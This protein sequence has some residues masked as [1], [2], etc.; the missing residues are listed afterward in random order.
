M[1]EL[2]SI[3]LCIFFLAVSALATH[4]AVLETM[5]DGS[6]KDAV[7]YSDRQYMTNVLREQAV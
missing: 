1:K 7:S 5:A 3:F 6:A 4:V 2:K